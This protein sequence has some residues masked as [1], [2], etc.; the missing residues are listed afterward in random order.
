VYAELRSGELVK[1]GLAT[2]ADVEIALG[3]NEDVVTRFAVAWM[4]IPEPDYYGRDDDECDP[5]TG[6]FRELSRGISLNYLDLNLALLSDE[7]VPNA[8]LDSWNDGRPAI[9]DVYAAAL[10]VGQY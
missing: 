2:I 7:L 5:S 4:S 3:A 6:R 10:G 9:R 8:P 1:L